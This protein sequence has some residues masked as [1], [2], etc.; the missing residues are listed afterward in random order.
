MFLLERYNK[1]QINLTV[2]Q[3]HSGL[4]QAARYFNW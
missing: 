4:I 2:D 1:Y 3:R